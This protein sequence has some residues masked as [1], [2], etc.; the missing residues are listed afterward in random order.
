MVHRLGG[1]YRVET[2]MSGGEG[3]VAL[4]AR[5][6]FAVVIS[7]QRMPGES[8]VRFLAQVRDAAPESV[9][10]MLTGA[11][12]LET[13]LDSINSG[14]VFRF[15]TKPVRAARLTEA[16]AA[17]VA[18]YRLITGQRILLSRTLH[19]SVKVLIDLLAMTSPDVFGHATRVKELAARL[20]KSLKCGPVWQVELASMLAFI[21]MLALPEETATKALTRTPLFG[22]ERE[23]YQQY[24]QHSLSLLSRIPRLE[25]IANIIR[26]HNDDHGGDK[27]AETAPLASRIIKVA[28]DFDC[29]LAQG[30]P[31]ESAIDWLLRS[32]AHSRLVVETLQ[33]LDVEQSLRLVVMP[34][35]ELRPGMVIAD[36]L[37]AN[38][39]DMLL[40]ARG[41]PLTDILI[42]RLAN[43]HRRG[44]I[45]PFV[46]V[47][48]PDDE[49]SPIAEIET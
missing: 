19:G 2:A 42:H 41:Q 49:S 6:P 21:G 27:G 40:L 17:A 13:A 30:L 11:P 37:R 3:L 9:R 36:D 32:P 28:S 29:L 18:Q 12:D 35:S 25:D 48:V 43:F 39:G 15:L 26:F 34:F 5:G 23:S 7:D 1:S 4:A 33:R 44:S 38:A 24:P 45:D 46:K 22:C 47:M 20:A 14:E 10:V 16:V 8:G 31:R